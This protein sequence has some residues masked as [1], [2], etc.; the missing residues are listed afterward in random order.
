M[1]LLADFLC[2][3]FLKLAKNVQK[4]S[5]ALGSLTQKYQ[6]YSTENKPKKSKLYYRRR[7]SLGGPND[8][9]VPGIV[10]N[11]SSIQLFNLFR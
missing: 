11:Y 6:S 9:I 5:N 3:H 7:F 10:E 2:K 1:F 4:L 8:P